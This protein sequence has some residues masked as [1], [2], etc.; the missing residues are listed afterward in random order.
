MT[1][2]LL[3]WVAPLAVAA[4]CCLPAHAQRFGGENYRGEGLTSETSSRT[5]ALPYAIA[6]LYAMI[7]LVVVCT[8]S[9]KQQTER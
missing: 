4:A 5:P 9:R 1:R 2:T 6:I 7:V 8:P 3:R